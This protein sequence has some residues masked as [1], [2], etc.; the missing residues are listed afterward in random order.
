MI[1]QL[2]IELRSDLCANVGKHYAAVI[3]LDTAL[4]E[5]GIP[6]IPARRLKGCMREIAQDILCL[7]EKQLNG[8]FGASGA[9]IPG[10]LRITDARIRE[11]DGELGAINEAICSGEVHANDITELFCSVRAETAIENDTAKEG[12]L[13]FTRVV[14]RISPIDNSPL[15]FYADIEYDETDGATVDLICRGLKNIGYKRNR[16]F[17]LVKC[18]L[19]DRKKGFQLPEK[20][21]DAETDYRLGFLVYLKED[22]MLPASDANHSM[23]Y[24]PGTSV[25]G[26]FASAYI[27]VYGDK[28]FNDVFFSNRVHFGNLYISDQKGTDYTPS[29]KFLAKIKAPKD[30]ENGIQNMIA[31][32]PLDIQKKVKPQYKPLKKGYVSE[33]EGYREVETEIVYHNAINTQTSRE[34]GG[35]LYTQHC[36]CAGQYFKGYITANGASMQ[37]LYP[38]LADGFL[39]FGRSKTAQ[40]SRCE[41]CRIEDIPVSSSEITL[42]HLCAGRIAAFLCESDILLENAGRYSVS[43]KDLCYALETK[44]GLDLCSLDDFTSLSSR[45]I[46]GYNT[47]WNLKKP[48]FPVIKAGSTV[49]FLI[50]QDAEAPE[51]LYIGKKQNEGCGQVRLIRDAEQYFSKYIAKE[52]EK[53]KTEKADF[54]REAGDSALLQKVYELQ[55]ETKVLK[56]AIN[57][58]ESISLRLNASQISRL[59]MMCRESVDIADLESRVKCIRTVSFQ[60]CAVSQLIGPMKCFQDWAVA[61]KYAD[62]LLTVAKYLIRGKED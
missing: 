48:Q 27:K 21:F 60:K 53:E 46:S 34:N 54:P 58:A 10:S 38:L 39:S 51:L 23:D 50:Q 47:K 24:I 41:I 8:L 33:T 57:D 35:G 4:D 11:Y 1:K 55:Y 37:K 45:V 36:L 44:S 56:Q 16:G 30:G 3:D 13:R 6:F 49:V 15:R 42:L 59:A 32:M 29:P 7:P 12:S 14:N 20:D 26:A 28:D 40:Y 52:K 18:K 61:K 25:R 9:E 43:L 5:N 31:N 17:G 2:E 22:V 19:T 62:S